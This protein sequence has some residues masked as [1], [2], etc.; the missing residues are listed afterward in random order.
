M[1]SK[2]IYLSPPNA[3]QEELEELKSVFENGWIAPV[4][5][6]IDSFEQELSNI[7]GKEVLAL[8]SGTSALHLAL[9][10]SGI[11]DGDHVLIGSHTF[12]ACANVVLYER[13]IPIFL[14]SEGK[15]WNLDPEILAEY[16]QSTQ[17]KPKALIVTHIY[18]MPAQIEEIYQ[19]ARAHDVIVIE[20]AAESIG[21]KIN[22]NHVGT[23]GDF[24]IFS[25]NGNK[26]ITT[27]GGGALICDEQKKRRGL[28]LATQANSGQFGYDHKEAGYNY[29]MSNVLA[30]IGLGQLKKLDRFIV[31]KK[32]IFEEYKH[33]LSAH[34][35][36]LDEPEGHVSNR[37]LT[38]ASVIDE[39][40]DVT[41][42]IA[43][44]EEHNIESRRFWKPLHLHDAFSSAEFYGNGLCEKIYEN[45][46]CLP[47]GTGLTNEDQSF[48]IQTIKE[49]FDQ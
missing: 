9:I 10:L 40:V 45:G 43:F 2:R 3:G 34:F 20:D 1:K 17:V 5:D 24:G 29:R 14:D 49:W 47:S 12:A 38:T 28:F 8:N 30:G 13:A 16:L 19:I 32:E 36:F 33:Q 15:T 18:G 6:A 46:L 42:L 39:S 37:W 4:G 35:T 41:E 23:V 21:A 31:K 44:L 25:F 26:L 11:G 27:G 22:E 7:Y 48:V